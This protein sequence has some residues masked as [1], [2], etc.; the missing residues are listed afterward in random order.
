M[1]NEGQFNFPLPNLGRQKGASMVESILAIPLIVFMGLGVI[2]FGLVYH[3]KTILNYA[4]FE[5]ARAGA[6]SNAQIEV[7][8]KELG[9]RLG[10]VY[11]GDGGMATA[12]MSVARSSVAVNDITTT[13]IEILNPTPE[14]FMT[15]AQGGHA[16][17]KDVVDRHNNTI[18]DV[19]VI[20]NSHLRYRSTSASSGNTIQDA[21][22]LKIEVTYGYQMRLPFLDMRVPLVDPVLRHLMAAYDPE[23]VMYYVRGMIPLKSVATVRMQSEAWAYQEQ[24]L[25]ERAFDAAVDWVQDQLDGNDAPGDCNPANQVNENLASGLPASTGVPL[26]DPDSS[27]T[28]CPIDTTALNNEGNGEGCSVD[29]T[30]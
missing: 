13:K 8:R 14:D 16:I 3:A 25:V 20:P 4:T 29:S 6:T 28:H 17:K 1:I 27:S 7:M 23:N 19:A 21:N 18:A 5:A 2:Q 15:R 30:G 11:G 22:L 9:Y 24:P 10:A 26:I 12:A